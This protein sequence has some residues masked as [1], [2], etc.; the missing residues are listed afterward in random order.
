MTNLKAIWDKSCNLKFKLNSMKFF[1]D[2]AYL[3]HL[4]TTCF[5]FCKQA[6]FQPFL[7]SKSNT[8]E[9]CKSNQFWFKVNRFDQ[10]LISPLC[11]Q[12]DSSF[13]NKRATLRNQEGFG[14]KNKFKTKNSLKTQLVVGPVALASN[15]FPF[16]IRHQN[17]E[18][19]HNSNIYKLC[20]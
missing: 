8:L 4:A 15:F 16:G 17:G 6:I 5:W 11:S 10:T 12:K 2:L 13:H 19:W 7:T 14:S 20:H 18:V 1:K 9:F 3:D